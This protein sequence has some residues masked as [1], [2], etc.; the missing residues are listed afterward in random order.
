MMSTNNTNNTSISISISK[1]STAKYRPVLTAEQIAHVITQLKTEVPLS[2]TGI[3]TI[4]YLTGFLFKIEQ[5]GAK[6]A[7]VPAPVK[8][9]TDTLEALGDSAT[10][11]AIANTSALSKEESWAKSY[12]IYCLTPEK[13]SIAMIQEAH[14]HMYLNDLMSTAQIE[15]FESIGKLTDTCIASSN[16]GGL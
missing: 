3:A 9:K 13:C 16:I 8:P 4:H 10:I 2:D 5:A 15:E 1:P 11:A 12:A 14:E 7:Y 6:P